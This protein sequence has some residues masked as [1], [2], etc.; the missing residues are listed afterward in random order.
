MKNEI[1]KIVK[2]DS[3]TRY[4]VSIFRSNKT[5]S[6]QIIDD[7]TGN[8][9]TSASS[10]KIKDKKNPSEIATI[11]GETLGKEALALK[12]EKIVFD[13]GKYRYHGRVKAIAEGLRKAG[14]I[15]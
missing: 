4:R 8:T 11:V 2:I 10:L 9:I 3:N 5:M 7:A 12:I 13:R 14:L 15:F 1:K 6:A